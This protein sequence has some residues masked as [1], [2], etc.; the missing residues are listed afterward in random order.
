MEIITSFFFKKLW[1]PLK[2]GNIISDVWFESG[3]DFCEGFGIVGNVGQGFN[4]IKP[5][6]N[7]LFPDKWFN[8]C[9]DFKNGYCSA[10][11]DKSPDYKFYDEN[12]N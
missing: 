6:G 7:L 4:Y 9:H 11:S 1:W 5:D 12:G 10:M 2:N 8:I 3:R